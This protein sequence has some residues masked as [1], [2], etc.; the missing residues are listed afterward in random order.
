M[1]GSVPPIESLSSASAMSSKGVGSAL[2]MTTRAP[3]DF[4]SDT[5]PAIG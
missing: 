3:A 4:A 1:R 5:A 2:T